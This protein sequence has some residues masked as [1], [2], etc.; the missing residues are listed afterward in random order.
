MTSD[1][2]L[3]DTPKAL[4]NKLIAARIDQGFTQ[5]EL[6]QAL[7]MTQSGVSECEED[8]GVRVTTALK[9]AGALGYRL[10]LVP[11]ERHPFQ[12]E[13]WTMGDA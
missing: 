8:G 6:A 7:F 10:A 1:P 3:I 12:D 5:T 11:M 9:W 13:Q 4:A 2:Y